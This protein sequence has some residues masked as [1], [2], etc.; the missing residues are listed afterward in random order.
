M[1]VETFMNKHSSQ[2]GVDDRLE[3]VRKLFEKNELHHLPVVEAGKL[4][5]IVSERDLLNVISPFIEGPAETQRDIATLNKRVHQVM[6]RKP[7]TLNP[8][9]SIYE[10]LNIFSSHTF[11]CIPVIDHAEKL[12]GMLSWRDIIGAMAKRVASK[13]LSFIESLPP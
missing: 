5:G 8:D 7:V 6:T 2:I 3:T 4:V 12:V 10:A 9:D 1:S 11:S 13:Q